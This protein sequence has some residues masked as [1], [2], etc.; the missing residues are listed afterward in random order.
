MRDGSSLTV[1]S[2]DRMMYRLASSSASDSTTSLESDIVCSTMESKSKSI[3]SFSK[4][5]ANER[6]QMLTSCNILRLLNAL[7]AS[8]KV[9]P[10]SVSM[11]EDDQKIRVAPS[12]PAC[13]CEVRVRTCQDGER[14]WGVTEH[15]EVRS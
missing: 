14:G 12:S 13:T 3:W 9:K 4:P 1:A 6:L 15:D 10:A 2:P 5:S 7:D 8:C 11:A